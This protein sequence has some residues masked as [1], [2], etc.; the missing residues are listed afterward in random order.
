MKV[1]QNVTV[2]I[3][4]TN[5]TPIERYICD[6]CGNVIKEMELITKGNRINYSVLRFVDK[7]GLCEL[8]I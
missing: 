2:T 3:K 5:G 6:K 7:C 8:K 1:V 4:I